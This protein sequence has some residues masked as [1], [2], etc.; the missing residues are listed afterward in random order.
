[1]RPLTTYCNPT[2]PENAP[3]VPLARTSLLPKV[4][5]EPPPLKLNP[6]PLPARSNDVPG[7]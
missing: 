7:W 5:S 1:M 3:S 6:V 4:S 2:V